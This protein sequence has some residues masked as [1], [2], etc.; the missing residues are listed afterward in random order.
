MTNRPDRASSFGRLVLLL[1]CLLAP[2]GAAGQVPIIPLR[3]SFSDPGARSM[4]FGG[5]F[6]ALADDATA[7][8][9]NPAGLVQLARPEVSVEGRRWAYSTPFTV[10]GRAENAPS[11]FGIDTTDGLQRAT[12][13][14]SVAGLSFLSLVYP[15]GDWAVAFFRHQLADFEFRSETQGIFGGGTD[16]C[17]IRHF[18]QRARI[19]LEI[20][21]FGLAAAYRLHDRLD[22]GLVAVYHEV[23]LSSQAMLFLPDENAIPSFFMPNSYF[24]ERS[25]IGEELLAE[26]T[27]WSLSAGLLWRPERHWRVG[28][29]FRQGAR[30]EAWNALVAGAAVDLGVPPGAVIVGDTGPLEFPDT[31]G[32]GVAFQQGALT[33]GFQWDRV[34]YS[35]LAEGLRTQ[36]QTVDDADELHLGMEYVL[37]RSTPV[38]ALR[39][40]VWLDPDHQLRADSESVFIRAL[41]PPGED[42]IH[43]AAGFGLA[44]GRFQ[45]DVGV[46]LSESVDTAAVSSVFSF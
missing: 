30:V 16:C 45:I 15:R 7:A 8:L 12:S 20:A 42:E 34:E 41:R 39:A 24:P 4:G 33:V 31:L 22:V 38:V 43:F 26:D 21:S 36:G 10:H 3:F 32:L 46:D 35:V 28:G 29:V 2:Q 14:D 40:G 13:D 27:D 37:L 17:Q 6:V 44:F 23:A 18:D 5:A 1:A 11:G 19:D 25:L 9:A